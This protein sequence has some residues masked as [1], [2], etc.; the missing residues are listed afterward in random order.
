LT[1]GANISLTDVA[2]SQID[3]KGLASFITSNSVTV[4]GPGVSNF[5][6]ISIYGSSS[7]PAIATATATIYEDSDSQLMQVRAGTLT[8]DSKGYIK[9]LRENEVFVSGTATLIAAE[10]IH[11]GRVDIAKVSAVSNGVGNLG[12][13]QTADS[14]LAD[15]K[16]LY[17]LNQTADDK[18]SS[19]VES[20]EAFSTHSATTQFV[21]KSE[22]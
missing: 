18:G 1:A 6:S 22:A 9:N 12:L 4:G 21:G 17:Q 3:V 16:F 2:N 7:N 10:Y 11:L 20:L 19:A 15:P 5:G 8:Y 14:T 13:T